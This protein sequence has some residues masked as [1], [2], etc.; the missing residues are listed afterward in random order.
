MKNAR[1]LVVD[2][3]EVVCKSC[4]RLLSEEGYEVDTS[5]DPE[6]G[7]TMAEQDPYDVILV[8]LKMPEVGGMEF[9]RRIKAVRPDT[10]VVIMTGFAQIATAV[11]ATKL[12][13][14]DYIPKPF[15]PDQL[16]VTVGK[17]LATREIISENRYLRRELESRYKFEN[18]VGNSKEMQAVY[19]L[20]ARISATNTTALIRGES[21]TGKELI[22]R[23]IHFNS[24]RKTKQF[25]AVDCGALHD[26]LLESELFGHVKGAF[27]GAVSAKKGL[28]EAA[29]GGTLFL[30]E[31]GSTSLILQTKLLRV[32]QERVFTPVGHTQ[33]QK[34]DVRL[35]TATNKDLEEMVAEGTFREELFYRLNIVPIQVPPLR[36]RKEDIPA[37]ATRFV[38]KFREET[39][40][41]VTGIS[42]ETLS[43]LLD[44]DWPGNVRELENVIHRAVVL[45]PEKTITSGELPPEIRDHSMQV[46]VRVPKTS[47]ELKMRKK[48]LREQSVEEVE[49]RFVAEALNRN[50]GNVS[51]AAAEVGMQRPNFQ[52]LMRKYG[53]TSSKEP[54][55]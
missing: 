13:A 42:P 46:T 17:A 16:A 4:D 10:E 5:L 31:I 33:E 15:S 20:I 45:A 51:R 48:E 27:T 35:I 49:R 6:K 11:E 41:E 28:F 34:T 52:A 8:D 40:C 14:F 43:L 2:D 18:I 38:E 22:A 29:D 32:L 23:A 1:I 26:N 47:D 7:L 53:I 3:E 19:E 55:S 54:T 25:V 39:G 44:Y 37:L 30:D 50:E 36:D 9:L 12:G 21:G 24:P